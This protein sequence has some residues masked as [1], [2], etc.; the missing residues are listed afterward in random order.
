MA[1]KMKFSNK[2]MALKYHDLGFNVSCISYLKT[3]YSINEKNPEKS[4]SHDWKEFQIRHQKI[5]ELKNY[6][7]DHSTGVGTLLGF[8]KIVCID[9]DECFDFGLIKNVL[10]ILFLPEDYQWVVKS[11]NGFHIYVKSTKLNLPIGINNEGIICVEP[12][13][14]NKN[15][16]KRV[17]FRYAGHAVLPN[18]VINDRRYF[19]IVSDLL[20]RIKP[21][22]FPSNPP[23]FIK[24]DILLSLMAY[25]SGTYKNQSGYLYLADFRIGDYDFVFS[26]HSSG[27]SFQINK[28]S[29]SLYENYYSENKITT[30]KSVES[31]IYI[32]IKTE[33]EVNDPTK[34][35]TYPNASNISFFI[36]SFNQNVNFKTV[37][38]IEKYNF[39]I[40]EYPDLNISG[41]SSAVNIVCALVQV[42]SKLNKSNI[43]LVLHDSEF[44]LSIFDSEFKRLGKRN[45]LRDKTHICLKRKYTEHNPLKD[46]NLDKIYEDLFNKPCFINK[47]DNLSKLETLMSCF[48]LMDLYGYFDSIPRS[49]NFR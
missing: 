28:K 49:F 10:K 15:N 11:P 18:S 23:D 42:S 48:K 14:K 8:T 35:D 45:P 43:L 5:E 3:P 6:E 29:I 46:L 39:Y 4:P 32:D 24:P 12:N 31:I 2:E 40:M 47:D 13:E 34:Y 9:I 33:E 7:W 21:D 22:I 1:F 30:P 44:K 25:L 37:T 38:N 20:G 19:F 27:P 16:F 26:Q 36:E 17:E 41:N